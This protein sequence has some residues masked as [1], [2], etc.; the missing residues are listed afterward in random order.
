MSAELQEI[1]GGWAAVG[2]GW[3]VFGPTREDALER[4]RDAE[5]KHQELD[6]RAATSS[7]SEPPQRAERSQPDA[8]A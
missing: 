7:T 5:A 8:Q 2:H 4:F 3:A 1:K 6:R